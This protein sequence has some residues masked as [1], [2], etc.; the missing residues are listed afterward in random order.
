MINLISWLTVSTDLSV[1]RGEDIFNEPACQDD[2]VRNPFDAILALSP[3]VDPR[4]ALVKQVS[5]CPR[6]ASLRPISLLSQLLLIQCFPLRLFLASF[7]LPRAAL[8]VSISILHGDRSWGISSMCCLH[9]LKHADPNSRDLWRLFPSPAKSSNL[10]KNRH[11][12]QTRFQDAGPVQLGVCLLFFNTH[13]SKYPCILSIWPIS[14]S[15]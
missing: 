4:R 5:S 3:P 14:S 15:P 7:D 10:D 11:V 8:R 12:V 1:P 2:H 13:P 6:P 9:G